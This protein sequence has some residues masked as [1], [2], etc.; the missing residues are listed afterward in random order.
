MIP[1][2]CSHCD[3][4]AE[5]TC[6]L[7]GRPICPDHLRM[8]SVLEKQKTLGILF[9]LSTVTAKTVQTSACPECHKQARKKNVRL[10]LALAACG[11][12]ALIAAVAVGTILHYLSPP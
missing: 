10:L 2:T 11:F 9:G 8:V 3:R 4:V 6:E 1:E 12:L 7:C 5:T